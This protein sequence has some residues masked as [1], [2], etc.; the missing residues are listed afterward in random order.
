ML[1]CILRGWGLTSGALQNGV[2][3]AN[4]RK[5]EIGWQCGCGVGSETVT[6]NGGNGKW[7]NFWP[8]VVTMCTSMLTLFKI[9]DA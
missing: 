1:L 9:W 2:H 5:R 4:D 6:A 3:I 8:C 7:K